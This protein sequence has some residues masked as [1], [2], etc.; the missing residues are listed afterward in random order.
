MKANE[1]MRC[2]MAATHTSTSEIARVLNITPAATRQRFNGERSMSVDNFS[3]ML[4]ICG[5]EVIAAPKGAKLPTDS[6][7]IDSGR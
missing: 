2:V 5:Y 3:E 7:K 4:D 6:F 1:V